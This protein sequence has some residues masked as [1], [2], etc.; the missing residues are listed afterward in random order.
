MKKFKFRLEALKKLREFKEKRLKVELGEILREIRNV[1]DRLDEISHEVDEGYRSQETV[2]EEDTE[3]RLI[4][5]YPMFFQGKAA[6]RVK[7][8]EKLKELNKKYNDKLEELKIA[9]GETKVL[10]K[11]EEKEFTKFKKTQERKEQ[12]ELEETFQMM[13]LARGER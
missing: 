3:G 6:D 2:L 4:K 12:E 9:R 8:K 1:E 13:K 7:N 11:L 10:E 5:F